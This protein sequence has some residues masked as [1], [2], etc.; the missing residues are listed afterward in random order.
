MGMEWHRD[1]MEDLMYGMEQ[2]FHT[3]YKFYTSIFWH[4]VAEVCF[5][6]V[7]HINKQRRLEQQFVNWEGVLRNLHPKQ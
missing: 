2:I 1:G 3:P 7:E 6:S 5:F 4:Y